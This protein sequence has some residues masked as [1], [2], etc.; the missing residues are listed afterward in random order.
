MIL[1]NRVAHPPKPTQ[2]RIDGTHPHMRIEIMM[3]YHQRSIGA[4]KI[5]TALSSN[6]TVARRLVDVS[7]SAANDGSRVATPYPFL[8]PGSPI[9]SQW[10]SGPREVVCIFQH[11][12]ESP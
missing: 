10:F 8:E 3:A 4:V 2:T 7:I 11:E 5:N 6:R 9:K 12:L 1:G